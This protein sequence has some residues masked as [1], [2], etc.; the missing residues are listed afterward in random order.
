MYLYALDPSVTLSVANSGG[1]MGTISDT[2]FI[3]GEA[4]TSTTAFPSE[5]TTPEPTTTTVNYTRLSD[6]TGT[7]SQ[8]ADTS[9]RAFPIYYS[10]DGVQAMT[11]T[12]MYDTFINPAIAK[13]ADGSDRPGTYR[14]HTATTLAGHTL[15]STTPVFVDTKADLAGMTSGEIGTSGTTQTDSTTVTNYYLF[16]TDSGSAIGYSSPVYVRSDTML[17]EYSTTN[18]NNMIQDFVQHGAKNNGSGNR[19]RYNLNGA[20]SNRGSGMVDTR[21]TS[22]SGT[23]N[24]LY[25]NTDDYR[26]QEFP[27][28]T[29]TAQTTTFLK[30]T[31]S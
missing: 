3:S 5:A 26:A 13:L 29:A 31:T 28:G 17:Q 19:I 7:T 9:S 8:P 20:G 1:S 27:T 22:T 25:V 14:I 11:A 10:T 6:A 2:R 30:I 21:I 16:R 4:R 12:D 24:T 18:F 15:I 23:V